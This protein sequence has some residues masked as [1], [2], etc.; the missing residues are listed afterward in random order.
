MRKNCS[1]R[2][3]RSLRDERGMQLIEFMGVVILIVMVALIIWQF[4]VF[5]HAS[6]IAN[7]AAQEGARAAAVYEPVDA[8]VARSSPGYKV[9][10]SSTVCGGKGDIVTVTVTLMVPTVEIP[11]I[12]RL[13]I[14]TRGVARAW[15]EYDAG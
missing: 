6:M 12:G 8:A 14:P 4:M 2:G 15:C 7:S 11:F 1:T 10:V 5:A 13:E 9:E 3:W